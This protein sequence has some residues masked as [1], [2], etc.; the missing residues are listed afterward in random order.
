MNDSSVRGFKA[1][2]DEQNTRG[3]VEILLFVLEIF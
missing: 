2:Q 1:L 3:I